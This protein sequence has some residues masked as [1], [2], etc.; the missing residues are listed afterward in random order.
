[1]YLSFVQMQWSKEADTHWYGILAFEEL[2]WCFSYLC[3]CQ[4][5]VPH[6]SSCR[7]SPP[8]QQEYLW[9]QEASPKS[10]TAFGS[11]RWCWGCSAT[12]SSLE[13]QLALILALRFTF[14]YE[15]LISPDA[16]VFLY[17]LM[18]EVGHCS[19]VHCHAVKEESSSW[20]AGNLLN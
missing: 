4:V 6:S 17:P 19:V 3:C 8:N 20:W 18:D 7:Q 1:M 5:P 15:E 11:W 2:C 16:Y 9:Q 12:E 14:I 10:D 13:Q